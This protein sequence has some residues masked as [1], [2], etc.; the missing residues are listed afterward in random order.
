M[1]DNTASVAQEVFFEYQKALRY[2]GLK[3]SQDYLATKKASDITPYMSMKTFCLE[4]NNDELCTMDTLLNLSLSDENLVIKNNLTMCNSLNNDPEGC[5]R[6]YSLETVGTVQKD[7]K[8][9]F[10]DSLF[11]LRSSH[12]SFNCEQQ[13]D[14]TVMKLKVLKSGYAEDKLISMMDYV[15][16]QWSRNNFK[17]EIQLVNERSSDV[18][19][20][21]PTNRS[22]SYV[23]DD[24]NRQIY[25]SNLLD[26]YAGKR[27]LVHEFGHVLGFPDCYTEFYDSEKK[28]LIYYEISKEDTNIMCSLKSG[29][30][31]PDDYMNQ[32]TQK[33]CVFN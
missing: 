2:E 10:Y 19:E 6:Q 31:V 20:L 28:S 17:L 5:Q 33:S 26:S 13:S 32:L 8:K 12:L 18:I 11:K 15:S 27:V 30:S 23:P 4:K 24:N 22:V 25:L 9:H 29:V 7:F 3:C 16:E 1:K 21:I 14:V